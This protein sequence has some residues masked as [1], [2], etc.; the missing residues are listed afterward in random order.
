MKLFTYLDSRMKFL[1][2]WDIALIKW[3][4]L[5][6]TLWLAKLF[7]VLLSAPVWVYAVLFV[8]CALKP[9]YMFY[10]KK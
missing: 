10:L 7:P 1:K 4:V 3:S 8:L 2:V 6:F 5:F 9:A